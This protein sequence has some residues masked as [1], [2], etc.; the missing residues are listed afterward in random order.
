MTLSRADYHLTKP[1]ML[2]GICTAN[3]RFWPGQGSGSPVSTFHVI[4]QLQDRSSH[5]LREMLTRLNGPFSFQS[6]PARRAATCSVR[7]GRITL[8][9]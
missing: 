7:V 8:R 6:S 1:W 4:G 9:S 2:S 3:Q 5:A